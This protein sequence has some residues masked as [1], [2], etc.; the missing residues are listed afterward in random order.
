MSRLIPA[1]Q[2]GRGRPL[3]RQRGRV[4]PP[5]Q[6]SCDWRRRGH[7]TT[8]SPLIGPPQRR[9]LLHLLGGHRQAPGRGV[10]GQ[11]RSREVTGGQVTRSRPQ[12]G[13]GQPGRLPQL[14]Q[15]GGGRQGHQLD[16][17]EGEQS[18]ALCKLKTNAT[19]SRQTTLWHS[20]K[21]VLKYSKQLSIG[22]NLADHL[23]EAPRAIAFK[24]DDEN[25][26]L[27]THLSQ[28]VTLCHAMSR[29]TPGGHRGGGH[30]P[31]H[32]GV[33]HRVPDAVLQPLHPHQQPRLEPSLLGRW[34]RA[35][36]YLLTN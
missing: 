12:V 33:Q 7:V 16:N 20:D 5:H 2:Y 15:R 4:Q 3:Q 35:G 9:A 36:K 25:I 28:H 18:L 26:F 29:V 21:L 23:V 27:V 22:D 11:V 24:P 6:V 1:P 32:H 14:L 10:A 31:G 13:P 30:L 34:G 19:S 17:R 8:C